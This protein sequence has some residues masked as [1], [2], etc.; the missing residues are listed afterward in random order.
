MSLIICVAFSVCVE[1]VDGSAVIGFPDNGEAED[2]PSGGGSWEAGYSRMI[3]CTQ[4]YGQEE[5]WRPRL[6]DRV[7]RR[8]VP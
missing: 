2:G 4:D 8:D 5:D 1:P 6:V 7:K 3:N